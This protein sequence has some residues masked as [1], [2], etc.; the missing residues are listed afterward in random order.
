MISRE[1]REA[2][3]R[4]LALAQLKQGDFAQD[5][6]LSAAAVSEALRPEDARGSE[7][8][9]RKILKGIDAVARRAH[10]NPKLSSEDREAVDRLLRRARGEKEPEPKLEPT[11]QEPGGWIRRDALNYI[12]RDIDRSLDRFLDRTTSPF[13]TVSGPV[14]SGRS[15]AVRRLAAAAEEKGFLSEV[16]DFADIGIMDE[17]WT[18]ESVIRSCYQRLGI[19]PPDDKI[20]PGE[21][22]AEMAS[23]FKKEIETRLREARR[24]IIVFDSLDTIARTGADKAK[25]ESLNAWLTALRNL[26]DTSPFDRLTI[27]AVA[28]AFE[29]PRIQAVS[30]FQLG[31]TLSTTK[32]TNNETCMLLKYYGIGFQERPDSTIR[33][34]AKTTVSLPDSI[35][36]EFYGHPFLTHLAVADISSGQGFERIK[37]TAESL[38]GDYGRHWRRIQTVLHQYFRRQ[39][40]NENNAKG[41]A[42]ELLK[43]CL[44]HVEAGGGSITDEEKT[45]MRNSGILDYT[46]EDY[47][48][49]NFYKTTIKNIEAFSNAH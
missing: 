15:S 49:C 20:E 23:I 37:N 38:E 48:I 34:A 4:L 27:V 24:G 26:A 12:E 47:K 35:F 18:P 14:Q 7:Q 11:L 10:E 45:L 42:D 5:I 36:D 16:V 33:T 6:R 29:W 39:G 30:A 1:Q 22:T 3:K 31:R 40:R 28:N 46:G 25:A 41:E 19:K 2:I 13:V 21:L 32:F 8:T 43:K 44:R 9:Y 17:T